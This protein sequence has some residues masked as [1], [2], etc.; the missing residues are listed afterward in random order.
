M[1]KYAEMSDD[2][3]RLEIC[4]R[5]GWT[6][7][8]RYRGYDDKWTGEHDTE[9]FGVTRDPIPNWPVSIEAAWEL[10]EEMDCEN[11]TI[12]NGWLVMVDDMS[13]TIKGIAPT[14]PRAI[15]LAWLMWKQGQGG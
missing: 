1:N 15:C 9:T 11:I 5:K 14:A 4:D 3:L 10:V 6:S 12:E 8:R 2:A 13:R 7:I